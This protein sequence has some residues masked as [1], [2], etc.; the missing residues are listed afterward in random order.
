M[1]NNILFIYNQVN[2]KQKTGLFRECTLDDDVK[3]I[4]EALLKTNY[5]IL[6]LD[7]Y[8]PDQLD[9]FIIDSYPI[10]FSFILAEGYK[11]YPHTLYNGLGASRIRKQLKAHN[12]PYSHSSIE[13]MEICRNKDLTYQKLKE[14]NIP[15]PKYFVFNLQN[16]FRRKHLLKEI[17]HLGY[18]LMVKPAG[19]G[20]S[21]G[22][23]SKSVIHN[24]DELKYIIEYLRRTLGPEKIIIEQYLSGQEFTVGV[25]GGEKMFILP[26]ISFPENWG[27]RYTETKNREHMMYNQFNI[28]NE[29]DALFYSLIDISVKSF[30]AVKANDIIRIDIKKDQI[31]NLYVIDI[32]GSPAL[33]KRASVAFM[34][35][36]AGLSQSQLIKLVF[37][38]SIV[39]NSL[40]PSKYL[41]DLIR[42]LQE[43]LKPYIHN[44]L[45]ETLL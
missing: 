34:A 35:S 28:V 26:I 33:T 10:D 42:P 38:N 25:L 6:S 3:D 21:I 16:R 15:I 44:Q 8:H 41:E 31:G 11:D 20:D 45:I 2:K 13:S 12:I 14:H 36:K 4:K 22:I 32:N 7:L 29:W 37:Y 5:N 1:P 24:I 39:R 27:I 43:K 18:P 19:G 40:S 23:T 9:K 17:E 30:Q